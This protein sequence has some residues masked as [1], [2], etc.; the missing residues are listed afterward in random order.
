MYIL[1]NIKSIFVILVKIISIFLIHVRNDIVF[2]FDI[3]FINILLKKKLKINKISIQYYN[4]L[5]NT[6]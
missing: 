3:I 1:Y 5:H 4:V 2:F 6:T